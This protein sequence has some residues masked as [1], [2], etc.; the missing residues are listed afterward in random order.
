[1]LLTLELPSM[2]MGWSRGEH[3]RFKLQWKQCSP[4]PSPPPPASMLETYFFILV[5]PPLPLPLQATAGTMHVSA[6]V[7]GVFVV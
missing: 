3:S 7:A 2:S 6:A 4:L 5:R 1:M